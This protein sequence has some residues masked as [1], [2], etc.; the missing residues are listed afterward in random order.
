M[1]TQPRCTRGLPCMDSKV[2]P[3]QL[4]VGRRLWC[5]CC[6]QSWWSDE[7]PSVAGRR[8]L[9]YL[10]GTFWALYLWKILPV[11]KATLLFLYLLHISIGFPSWHSGM[12]CQCRRGRR[13]SFDPWVGKIPWRRAWQ[14]APVFLP[15]KPHGPRGLAGCSPQGCKG[16]DTTERWSLRLS[17]PH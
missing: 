6:L 4:P 15:G 1:V 9:C 13:G 3:W 2:G 10:M 11:G 16:L 17:L 8:V 14:P 7:E 12:I 5:E